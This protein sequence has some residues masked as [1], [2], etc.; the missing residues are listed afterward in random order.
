MLSRMNAD[1]KSLDLNEIARSSGATSH[2][3]GDAV[4]SGADNSLEETVDAIERG[5]GT[6]GGFPGNSGDNSQIVSDATRGAR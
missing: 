2:P 5:K 3:T 4:S 1:P 6:D